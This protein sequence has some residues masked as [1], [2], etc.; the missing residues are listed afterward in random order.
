[1]I[2]LAIK[3]L[4]IAAVVTWVGGMLALSL[5]LAAVSSGGGRRQAWEGRLIATVRRWDQRV[6]APAMLLTWVLGLSLAVAAEWFP[7]PWLLIKLALVTALSAL[8]GVQSGALRRH[9][10]DAT[11]VPNRLVRSGGPLV[12]A[13]LPLIILLAVMKPV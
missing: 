9:V 1:M 8:H 5:A 11:A 4:H 3:T 12:L 7:A 13:T 10:S 6:T 2:Y